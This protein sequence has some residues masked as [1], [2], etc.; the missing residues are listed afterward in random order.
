MVKLLQRGGQFVYFPG[1]EISK[2][3]FVYQIIYVYIYYSFMLI[4]INLF[5]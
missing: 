4:N 1:N 2:Y 5:Y 3:D